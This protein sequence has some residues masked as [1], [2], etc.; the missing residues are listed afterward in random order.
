VAEAPVGNTVSGEDNQRV[1][2]VVTDGEVCPLG[3]IFRRG[4]SNVD[5]R[6]NISDA[7]LT[8]SCLFAGGRCSSCTDAGDSNDDGAL[9]VSDATYL[10]QWRF[11]GGRPPPGPFPDCSSDTTPDSLADCVYDEDACL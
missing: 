9:D 3:A 10:L 7:V 11:L 4:D 8:L 6:F 2:A 5:G 1:P